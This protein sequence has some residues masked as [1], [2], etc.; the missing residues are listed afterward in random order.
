M[1]FDI[2]KQ[3]DR[4]LVYSDHSFMRSDERN[5]P[6][7]KYIPLNAV[8]IKRDTRDNR[9]VYTMQYEFRG[10]KY[11]LIVEDHTMC[12]RTVYQMDTDYNVGKF[13]STLHHIKDKDKET[14]RRMRQNKTDEYYLFKE[15]KYKHMEW[16]VGY[17]QCA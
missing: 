17:S 16:E 2:K 6:L 4:E 10:K 12:V 15:G 11:I 7:P 3:C 9:P 1:N 13:I 8:F 14:Q 5:V